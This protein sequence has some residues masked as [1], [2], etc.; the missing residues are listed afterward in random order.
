MTGSTRKHLRLCLL[1]LVTIAVFRPAGNTMAA[2][3]YSPFAGEKTSWHEGFD[4]Y[5]FV[6]DDAT[7]AI[8]P[9]V[10]PEKEV[11]SFG[12]DATLANGKRRCVVIVP[13]KAAPGNP[14]S[15]QACYWNHEP[16]TEVELLKRGFHIA[17]V[18]P[19]PGKQWEAWYAWLPTQVRLAGTIALAAD[20]RHI[21]S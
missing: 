13:K 21:S 19:D 6:M 5:D 8:T 14:W 20:G 9:M 15:W 12:I 11:T 17:F 2:D 16:Q 3:E 18:A 10:A 1:V 4:R 7:G